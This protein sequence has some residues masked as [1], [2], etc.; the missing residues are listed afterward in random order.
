MGGRILLIIINFNCYI[1][2]LVVYFLD[3]FKVKLEMLVMLNVEGYEEIFVGKVLFIEFSV[4]D[5]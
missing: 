5:D 1:V 4:R 2:K 3:Y